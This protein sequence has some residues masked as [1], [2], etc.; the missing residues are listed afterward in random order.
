[1]TETVDQLVE[2][3]DARGLPWDLYRGMAAEADAAGRDRQVW[4]VRIG[5]RGNDLTYRSLSLEGVLAWAAEVQFLPV[6]PR[7]PTVTLR[8]E[9]RKAGPGKW[10]A[11]GD[12]HYQ[13][14]FTTKKRAEELIEMAKDAQRK[15]LDD[16]A[17]E[18]ADLVAN[19]LPDVDFRWAP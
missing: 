10:D 11:Y 1:M 15:A 3:V 17:A 12:G 5:E 2:K 13:T 16:W 6:V 9:V 8:W 4:I 18:W 19:G 7:R 14:Q